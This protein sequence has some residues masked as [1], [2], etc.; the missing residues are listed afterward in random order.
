MRHNFKCCSDRMKMSHRVKGKLFR[1]VRCRETW[2]FKTEIDTFSYRQA[3]SCF[4]ESCPGFTIVQSCWIRRGNTNGLLWTKQ[5]TWETTA[6]R[7]VGM[8]WY[9][10]AVKL[11]VLEEALR[12]GQNFKTSYQ[13]LNFKM[14]IKIPVISRRSYGFEWDETWRFL[15]FFL[16]GT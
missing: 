7:G 5:Q 2:L 13:L 15:S 11:K 1:Y 10:K 14:W 9:S 12:R 3:T 16:K 4:S 8:Y 6:L